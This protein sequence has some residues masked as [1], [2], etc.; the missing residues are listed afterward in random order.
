MLGFVVFD[1]PLTLSLSHK[2]RGTVLRGTT[3]IANVEG[4]AREYPLP[5]R[6]RVAAKRPGEGRD[7]NDV[8]YKSAMTL[9]IP[10][11]CADCGRIQKL[12]SKPRL[13]LTASSIGFLS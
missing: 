13:R 10:K 3:S 12:D 1:S 7:N 5:L 2:G 6:E 8:C 4:A 9:H 11:L